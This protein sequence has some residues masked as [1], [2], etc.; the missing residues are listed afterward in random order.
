M[1]EGGQGLALLR[2]AASWRSTRWRCGPG[3]PPLRRHLA[4]RQGLRGRRRGQVRDLLR[5]RREVRLGARL[6]QVRAGC[7]WRPAPRASIYRVDGHG[8]GARC[9]S[10]APRRTSTALAV[11]GEGNVYAGSAP[12]RHP[13]PH[14]PARQGVRA[15][16]LRLPRGEGAGGRPRTAA[17]RGRHRRRE[18]DERS[19]ARLPMPVPPASRR[20]RTRRGHRDRELR[21]PVATSAPMPVTAGAARRWSGPHR[22]RQGRAAAR[23]CPPAKWTRCGPRPRRRPTRWRSRRTACCVGTGNKGTGLPRA[24]TTARW[25][26]VATLPAEQVT[27]LARSGDRAAGRHV[28]PRTGPRARLGASARRATFTSKVKDTETVSTWGRLALG[29]DGARRHRSRGPD[30]AAATPATPTPRGRT[31]RRPTR[32][33]RATP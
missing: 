4:G 13:L 33:R 21:D 31:G 18:Q 20:P 1:T 27:A 26:M 9:C 7:W 22:A 16:R 15:A 25:A 8:Q 24:A 19:R 30:R 10:P 17:V 2:R 3:R 6:R 32:T 14:R 28:E 5:S 11:D 12:A 23:C 29:G